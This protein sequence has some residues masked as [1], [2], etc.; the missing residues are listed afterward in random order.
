MIQSAHN[1][2]YC[3]NM[4]KK[5]FLVV[6]VLVTFLSF[7]TLVS[8]I[9]ADEEIRKIEVDLKAKG[10]S[11]DKWF[12]N[13]S[14]KDI[15]F[16]PQNQ[17]QIQ[18]RVKNLG[19]RNQTNV[20]IYERLPKTLK[21]ISCSSGNCT[22]NS[23][24]QIVWKINQI[25]T[26]DEFFQLVTVEVKDK[27]SINFAITKNEVTAYAKTEIG[28]ENSDTLSFYTNMG[29]INSNTNTATASAKILPATG[30]KNLI[31]GT[32]V[33]TSLLALGFYLRKY[34]RGY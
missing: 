8:P 18:L 32:I 16:A 25:P 14:D 21:L 15:I 7:S 28:T 22:L 17:F 26:N 10:F 4:I 13:L 23:F 24:N 3:L 1:K 34:A 31:I 19:N 9:F 20:Q 29:S 5:I 27:N 33:S 11:Q 2:I 30:S 12:D 6:S